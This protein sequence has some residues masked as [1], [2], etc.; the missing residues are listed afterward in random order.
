MQYTEPGTGKTPEERGAH[1]AP[2]GRATM[3]DSR[4]WAP[5]LAAL[6]GVALACGAGACSGVGD[7][8]FLGGDG[9][10]G[11]QGLRSLTLRPA[12]LTLVQGLDASLKQAYTVT[13]KFA[14]G[15]TRDLTVQAR[16]SLADL[17][18]GS[19][20]GATLTTTK[21]RGGRT[22]VKAVVGQVSGTTGLLVKVKARAVGGGAPAGAEQTFAAG[23]QAPGSSPRHLYP[24]SGALV[25]PNLGELEVMWSDSSQND[26]WEVSLQSETVDLRGYAV[27]PTF[28]LSGTMWN[29]LAYSNL[30]G[31]VAIK[32][33]GMRRA[34]PQACGSSTPVS[35]LLA[36]APVNGG[37]YYWA[38]V[39]QGGVIRYDFGKPGQQAQEVYTSKHAG[40]CVGCHA[41][42]RDGIHMALTYD[43]GN[44]PAGILDL[45]AGSVTAKRDY[46][47]NFQVFTPDNLNLIAAYK[48]ELSVRDAVTGVERAK[49]D[50]QGKATMPEISPDGKQL[51]FVRPG[52]SIE[53]WSF[54]GGSIVT[55]TVTGLA[56]GGLRV[57][58][59][60]SV[61]PN[62]NN[63]CPAFSPDGKVIIFNRSTGDS[64]S[65][66]DAALYRI[67]TAGGTPRPLARANMGANLRNSW[68]RWSPFVQSYKKGK[69]FWLTISSTRD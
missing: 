34:A 17:T 8:H 64:Y 7:D 5:P 23:C 62:V 22:V 31:S 69:L 67:D 63:Y 52:Q 37:L 19:F 2:R 60:G 47:A 3:R 14:D 39:E 4:R 51:V 61:S 38:A 44:G 21:N 33:R 58:V 26:L 55:A 56:V 20:N 10:G 54:F 12:D 13:G 59:Q 57:L 27:Q 40:T 18:L 43:G 36:G 53:D 6:Y 45:K 48:G 15:Q 66:N 29:A 50:T 42:S 68:A 25:P 30:Q 65:N 16:L 28:K 41:I 32:V 11:P 24:Q 49:L 1:E 35:L 46:L 9:G